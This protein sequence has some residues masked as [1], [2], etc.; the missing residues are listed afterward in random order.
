[1]FTL[2]AS[3]IVGYS[4][5]APVIGALGPEGPYYLT[6][7]MFLVAA[8][9][10]WFLPS[11]RVAETAGMSFARI[12]RFTGHEI[13]RNWQLIRGNHNLSFPITQLTITQASLGVLLALAPALALAVLHLPIQRTSH[14]L[15]IP[16]GVGM[17]LGVVAINHLVK[18]YSKVRVIAVGLIVASLALT[19]LGLSSLLY[20]TH[21]GHPIAGVES[22]GLAVAGLVLILGFMNALVSAA[23][24]T[25]LQ[26]NTTEATRGKVFGALNMMV[27]IA[28]TLPIFFA[29]ILADLTSVNIVISSLGILLLAFSIAQYWLL[30]RRHKLA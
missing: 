25:I 12:V 29:G 27:N 6:S 30:R 26:E 20:R 16:A 28:A 3:F 23:A 9:F 10:V 19:M 7:A 11:I 13:V 18:L 8:A 17:V 1:V 4:A 15:I 24:Q 2:Y 22:I 5:S 14:Y 21:H